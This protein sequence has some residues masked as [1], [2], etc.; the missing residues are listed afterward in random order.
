[1]DKSGDGFPI[2]A[3]REI[4]TLKQAR[5]RHIVDLREVVVGDTSNEVYLV[6]EFLEHDLK[7]LQEEMAEPFLPSEIKTLLLQI[8]AGVEFL[9]D[10]WILHRDL[11][12][13]NILL[14]NRGEI[15]LADFGMARTFSDPPPPNLTQ[16]V[17]TLWYRAPELL[18]GTDRYGPA[19][20]V[21]SL[22]CI[23]GELLRNEPLLPG[24]TEADQLSRIFALVGAPTDTIWPGFRRLPNARGLRLPNN[25]NSRAAGSSSIRPR[26]PLLTAAGVELLKALLSLDP[27]ARPTAAEILAHPFFAEAPRPKP[28]A[29]FPS[30][31][32]K[33]GGERRRRLAS[34]SAPQ[35]GEAPKINLDEFSGIFGA[36]EREEAGAGF[37]LRVS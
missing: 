28:T 26:F 24:R 12:T 11:K 7:T 13:S 21:W 8:V 15:R 1:M 16:L 18:L 6:M 31:P 33:A 30:F 17:V 29:M 35:L 23:F 27:A 14:N 22:G 9:H 4:Q 37:A 20:D 36:S 3:L 2:T 19:I 5:H 25:S 10:N 34:P 32:S